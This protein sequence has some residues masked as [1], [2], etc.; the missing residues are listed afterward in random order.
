MAVGKAGT[1]TMDK[2]EGAQGW[3]G[4]FC[5]EGRKG[6]C[7]RKRTG[8]R[9]ARVRSF[10]RQDSVDTG[11]GLEMSGHE[12]LPSSVFSLLELG[13]SLCP[14]DAAGPPRQVTTWSARPG[15]GG[16]QELSP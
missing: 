14:W 13:L 4:W 10:K 16:A 3:G 12:L 11:M 5:R 1:V 2:A 6:L 9:N 7:D 15:C 8:G